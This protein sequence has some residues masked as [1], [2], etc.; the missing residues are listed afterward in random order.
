MANPTASAHYLGEDLN[1]ESPVII[2]KEDVSMKRVLQELQG[3][4][5]YEFPA[6]FTRLVTW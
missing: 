3:T 5:V 2:V 4:R 6:F 1:E